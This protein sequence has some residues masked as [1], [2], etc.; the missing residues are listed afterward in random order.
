M[1]SAKVIAD[2]ISGNNRLTTME[3]TMH[4][5]ILPEFNTHRKF[6][7]NAGSSRAIPVLKRI[8]EVMK[9]PALPLHWGENKP[10]MQAETE[11]VDDVQDIVKK[12]WLKSMK[13]TLRTVKFLA[14]TGLHK[15]TA[16]R[17]LEPFLWQKVIVSSTEWKN[18]FDQRDSSLAQPEMQALA[19][20]MKTALNESTPEIADQ[21]YWHLPYTTRA[22]QGTLSTSVLIA[23][24]VA[25]CARVSYLT[26]EGKA[27]MMKDLALYNRLISAEPPHWSPLE[28]VAR[29][30]R[31]WEDKPTGNFDGWMQLRHVPE[32]DRPD[33]SKI[34][35]I[36]EE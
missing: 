6:S 20:A 33:L 29:P 22:E 3:V 14:K 31:S 9:N 32:C 15:Q 18:F 2:S 30:Y 25:R 5:F 10:G 8:E 4:R 24:S 21:K 16:N 13:S 11:L 27:D 35:I 36:M 19:K 26:H 7:R 28:H 1:I 23:I 12:A 34:P 17:L